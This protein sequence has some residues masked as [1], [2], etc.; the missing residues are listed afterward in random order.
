MTYTQKLRDPRWQKKRLQIF[1]RDDWKCTVCNDSKSTLHVHHSF[2][3]KDAQPWDYE[4][5]NLQTLC[6][7][8]H[9][10]EH[11]PIT[12][13]ECGGI[14]KVDQMLKDNPLLKSV[15]LEIGNH[16]GCWTLKIRNMNN[17]NL[18]ADAVDKLFK[19][20]EWDCYLILQDS[21]G[22]EIYNDWNDVVETIRLMVKTNTFSLYG[23]TLKL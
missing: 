23:K 10:A 3:K 4:N 15:F 17:T 9:E 21:L 2:Y 11:N 16:K 12:I 20:A 13:T 14:Y 18:L 22:N 5:E 1:D 19:L 7:N 6:E 8:C